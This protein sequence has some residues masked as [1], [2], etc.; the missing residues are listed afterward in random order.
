MNFSNT[1]KVYPP[2]PEISAFEET[3]ESG[4]TLYKSK[5]RR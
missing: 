5:P 2:V 4:K 1:V 3:L